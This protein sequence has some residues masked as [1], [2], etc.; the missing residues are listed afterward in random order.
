VTGRVTGAGG[1]VVGGTVIGGALVRRTVV[2]GTAVGGTVVGGTVVGGAV[3]RATVV[4]GAVVGG[5]VVRGNV[6]GGTVTGGAVVLV[7]VEPA[8]F[9]AVGTTTAWAA[10]W[11]TGPGA[12]PVG[13]DPAPAASPLATAGIPAVSP[14]TDTKVTSATS[15]CLVVMRLRSWPPPVPW[16]SYNA[17]PLREAG[18]DGQ[19]ALAGGA[20]FGNP[21]DSWSPV[22]LRPLL[23]EGLPLI[24]VAFAAFSPRYVGRTPLTVVNGT[25]NGQGS[26]ACRR[27]VGPA[28]AVGIGGAQL[29]GRC[30]ERTT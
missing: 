25:P 22:V 16:L 24:V 12:P 13:T 28:S 5:T 23:A 8:R 10:A 3:V 18:V 1:A 21:A 20:R 29:T 11:P 6:V 15:R 2:R 14:K 26:I 19:V 9:S 4:G 7:G 17:P 27:S 30:T